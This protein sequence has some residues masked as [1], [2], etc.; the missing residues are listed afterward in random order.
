M[1]VGVGVNVGV[2]VG[3]EVG[4]NVAV[5]VSVGVM[6]KVEV[7]QAVAAV[8]IAA[9]VGVSAMPGP[10]VV[11]SVQGHFEPHGHPQKSIVP[12]GL[13]HIPDG[14]VLFTGFPSVYIQ[15]LRDKGLL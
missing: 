5:G 12:S 15:R 6:V 7:G 10:F 13:T 9:T 2:D 3:V 11:L 4:V 14:S 1:L 8:T